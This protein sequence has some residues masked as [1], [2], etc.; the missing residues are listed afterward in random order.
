MA[1]PLAHRNAEIHQD[2]AGGGDH[3]IRR[4]DVAVDDTGGM[5]GL[6]GVDQL[7]RQPFQI[8]A[9]IPA[10]GGDVIAQV[11]ALDQFGDDER[12]R[13]VQLHIHNAAYPRVLHAAQ[14]HRLAAQAFPCGQ[15]FPGFRGIRRHVVLGQRIAQD[16]HGVFLPAVIAHPPH[17]TH[18]AGSQTGYQRVPPHQLAG[19]QIQFAHAAILPRHAVTT[20][21]CR[22]RQG[23]NGCEKRV[24]P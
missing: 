23:M 8:G 3:H 17:G 11:L 18:R 1:F 24:G 16:L 13:I 10:V 22:G 5:H 6:D 14:R 20:R 2:R 12:Q 9:H 4:L 7:A 19:F 15:P 21:C